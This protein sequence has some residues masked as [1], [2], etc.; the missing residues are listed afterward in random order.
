MSLY[1]VSSNFLSIYYYC[2]RMP[3]KTPPVKKH[4]LWGFFRRRR[5]LEG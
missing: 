2:V 4:A 5:L 1:H 3:N